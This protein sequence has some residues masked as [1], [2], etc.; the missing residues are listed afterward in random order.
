MCKLA[1]APLRHSARRLPPPV[2]RGHGDK[3]RGKACPVVAV[4][5]GFQEQSRNEQK[6]RPD[7]EAIR[8]GDCKQGL[9]MGMSQAIDGEET[10]GDILLGRF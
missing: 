10:A 7:P 4:D 2:T 8:I 1:A 6:T 3:L 9:A 5:V